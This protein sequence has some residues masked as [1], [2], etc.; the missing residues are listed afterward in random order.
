MISY[1]RHQRELALRIR[2][3]LI[4][5]EHGPRVDCLDVEYGE[6]FQEKLAWWLSYCHAAIVLLSAEALSSP[7]VRYELDVLVNRQRLDAVKL[8]CVLLGGVTI[9]SLQGRP[10]LGPVALDRLQAV[11]LDVGATDDEIDAVLDAI[12]ELTG[13]ELHV[14]RLVGAIHDCLASVGT[15]RLARARS[16]VP[17]EVA[18]GRDPWFDDPRLEDLRDAGARLRWAL[19][20]ELGA[21]PVGALYA[22]LQE[23]A[24]DREAR[25]R[26]VEIAETSAMTLFDA[27]SIDALR[28][29]I[30]PRDRRASRSAVLGY[31]R[32]EIAELAPGAVHR[33]H[34][35]LVPSCFCLQG[36]SMT[37]ATVEEVVDGLV[38][39]LRAAIELRIVAI[40][41]AEVDDFIAYKGRRKHPLVVVL[42]EAN[43]LTPEILGRLAERL[44]TMSF[45]VLATASRDPDQPGDPDTWSRRLDGLPVVGPRPLPAAW[46]SM[47]D[48]EAR[49]A[50][51]W[52]S[53]R[54][55]L[56]ACV[57]EPRR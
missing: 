54:A 2:T 10:E 55:D 18:G 31:S 37:G 45:V 47:L 57:A 11:A 13:D 53:I 52:S 24:E 7:W 12:P 46:D 22:P 16:H 19:A 48:D 3:R 5:R 20:A 28:E 30:D 32:Q 29:I 43:G 49:L 40:E 14:E 27:S 1:S 36:P 4:A 25:N 35:T 26:V 23:L 17:A 6:R 21:A 42:W 50:D 15:T 44:P 41:D 34:A 56:V 8:I 38:D 51:Q 9:K 39:Q 33:V